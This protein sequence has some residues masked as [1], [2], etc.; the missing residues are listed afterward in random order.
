MSP[1][2]NLK[3]RT[4][5]WS[6]PLKDRQGKGVGAQVLHCGIMGQ[7]K[8]KNPNQP[9]QKPNTLSKKVL[10]GCIQ[11]SRTLVVASSSVVIKFCASWQLLSEPVRPAEGPG[12]AGDE[13]VLLDVLC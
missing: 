7:S 9:N 3:R 11:I 8:T 5:G 10:F 2:E 6:Y 1:W 4:R 12:S 13:N